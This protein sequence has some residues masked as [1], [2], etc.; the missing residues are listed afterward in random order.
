MCMAVGAWRG[1]GWRTGAD[2]QPLT[3]VCH[4]QM[5]VLAWKQWLTQKFGCGGK[6]TEGANEGGEDVG[7]VTD[8]EAMQS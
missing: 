5:R 3:S 1:R 7:C 8:G 4:G 2:N 6:E